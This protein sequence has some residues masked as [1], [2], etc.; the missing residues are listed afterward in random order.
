MWSHQSY[1]Y[2][3]VPSEYGQDWSQA[4]GEAKLPEGGDEVEESCRGEEPIPASAVGRVA[5]SFLANGRTV[6]VLYGPSRI[7]GLGPVL[8][9]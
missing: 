2:S 7:S 6:I 5:F 8:E 4:W 9:M 1:S 3:S